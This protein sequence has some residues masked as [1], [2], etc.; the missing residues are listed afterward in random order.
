MQNTGAS[1][2]DGQGRPDGR[3]EGGTPES[4]MNYCSH[5]GKPVQR[6][7]PPGD[8]RE[9]FM[10]PA[11]GR[12]HYR[13]P[14]VV[15]GCIPVWQDRVLLCRRAI[16]P[17]HGSWTIPAGYLENGETVEA[18]ARR[19][20]LEEAR[21]S[22]GDLRPFGLYNIAHVNQVYLIFLAPLVSGDFG[23]GAETSE[24]RL[25]DESEIPWGELAFPVVEMTLKRYLRD[26]GRGDWSFHIDDVTTRMKAD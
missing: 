20:L 3:G 22:A 14:R 4:M 17:R 7:I 24:V 8:D 12:I 1:R 21:A 15:V 23:A 26:A 13:N 2:D 6:G 10:C 18:G 19:E 16:E 25:F 5:C 11:C 9:R